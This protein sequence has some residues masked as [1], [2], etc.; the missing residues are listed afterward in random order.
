MYVHK[1]NMKASQALKQ[2]FREKNKVR[3]QESEDE[4]V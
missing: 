1:R 3:L 2:F 4:L